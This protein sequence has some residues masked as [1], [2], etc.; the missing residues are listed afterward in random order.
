MKADDVV[1]E[2][3]RVFGRRPG[4]VPGRLNRIMNFF[5]TRVISR[6]RAVS[7]MCKSVYSIYGDK[8]ER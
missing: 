7:I 1:K 5:M 4:M 6:K 2:A 8:A 3:L